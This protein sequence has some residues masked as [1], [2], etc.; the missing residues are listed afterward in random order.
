[1]RLVATIFVAI[2]PACVVMYLYDLPWMGFVIGLLALGAAWFGGEHFIL[3]QVR[4]LLVTARRLAAG[5]LTSRTQLKD[6]QGELGELAKT[7]G[8]MAESLQVRARESETTGHLLT[9]RAQQQSVV[10]ALGQFALVSQDFNALVHQAITMIGQALEVELTHLLELQP[11]GKALLMRAGVGWEPGCVGSAV[12]EVRGNSEAAFELASG[13]PQEIKPPSGPT[14]AEY[15]ISSGSPHEIKPPSGPTAAEYSISSGSP[16]ERTPA[17][18]LT[19]AEYCLSS[20]EP[21][22]IKNL[23]EEKRFVAPP[24]FLEHGILSGVSVVIATRQGPY[25]VLAAYSRTERSYTG[26]EINF[27][28]AVAT[29]LGLAAERCQTEAELQRLAAFAQLSPN[30]ALE[31]SA[32]GTINYFNDATLKLALSV[33][34]DHPRAVLPADVVEIVGTCLATG[35]SKLRHETR[36]AGRTLAWAFHPVSAR[37][38]E[39]NLPSAP[40][41]PYSLFH[42]AGRVVHCYV[43]D[44]TDRLSLE[45]QLRQSQKMESVGQLAAGVAHDFNNMLT[46]IQGHSGM[47]MARPDLAPALLDSAQAIYFASERAAGLTRQLLMFSRKNVMQSKLLDLREVVTTMTKMLQRL[48]GETVTLEFKPPPELPLVLGDIGMLEQVLMNLVVNA[49]DAMPKGGTLT[50]TVQATDITEAHVEKNPEARVGAFVCLRVSDT[51][52]GMDTTIIS[53][54]FEPFFTTKEVGQGTGLGLA[55]VYGIVKQHEGWIAV[56]SQVGKGSAFSVFLPARPEQ[57]QAVKLDADPAASIRGGQESILIVE[58]EPVLREL[59]ETILGGCGYRIHAAGTGREA[60]EVWEQQHGALDLLLTDMVMPEGVS[61]VEL[62]EKLLSRRP[63]LKVIFASGYTVDEVS[64]AFLARNNARFLQKPYTR[65][66]LARAVREALDNTN[67]D[68]A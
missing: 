48:V 15:C 32:E 51:G 59:A 44:I 56:T 17:S 6:N 60:L 3:R 5:D 57:T 64:E 34:C 22:V 42:G 39:Y 9:N 29:A 35:Q 38:V 20:G 65:I 4:S 11:D 63:G 68:G 45:A 55:T 21:V 24:L 58:D 1:M 19:A 40:A 67:A 16:R 36:F 7:F 66:T 30:P 12:I 43:E 10:A 62:A 18:G 23:R 49:R 13:S 2:A 46:I 28:V 37:P 25:G 53:R 61:G 8:Q 50:I 14:A 41:Q 54:I 27:M 47:M 26:D 52:T 33:Q 31:L